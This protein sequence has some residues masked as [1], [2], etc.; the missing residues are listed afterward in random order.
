MVTTTM[1]MVA[2]AVMACGAVGQL[3]GDRALD[4]GAVSRG[5]GHEGGR[6]TLDGDSEA[7]TSH[8]RDV[9]GSIVGG[10][11][12]RANCGVTGAPVEVDLVADTWRGEGILPADLDLVGVLSGGHGNSSG[13]KIDPDITL[14]VSNGYI[15][16]SG[17]GRHT[18]LD[19]LHVVQ[20]VWVDGEVGH[21]NEAVGC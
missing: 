12:G 21:R 13:R 20:V 7:L 15:S 5:N 19:G 17:G 9:V 10:L 18:C 2:A 14:A 4:H 6:A 16:E 11:I 1:A 8:I 3:D